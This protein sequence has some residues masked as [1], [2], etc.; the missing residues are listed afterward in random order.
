MNGTQTKFAFVM[1]GDEG[2][3]EGLRSAAV[4]CTNDGKQYQISPQT[5]PI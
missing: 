1:L 4:I 2:W 3:I 5:D